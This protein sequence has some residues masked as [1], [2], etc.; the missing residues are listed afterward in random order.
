MAAKSSLAESRC[1]GCLQPLPVSSDFAGQPA[2]AHRAAQA[3][4][5]LPA[6][7]HQRQQN[8]LGLGS[9]AQAFAGPPAAALPPRAA[10]QEPTLVLHGTQGLAMVLSFTYNYIKYG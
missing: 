9:M 3:F 2:A 6:A 8:Q 7:E 4:A 10:A 1:G 5:W